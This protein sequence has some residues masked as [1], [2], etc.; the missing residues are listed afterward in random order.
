MESTIPN[1]LLKKGRTI[2]DEAAA[3]VQGGIRDAQHAA[4]EAGNTLSNKVDD[5]RSDAD[6]PIKRVVS[7]VKSVSR[8]GADAVGD[9]ASRVRDVALNTSDSIVSYTKKNPT[10]ALAIAAASGALLYAAIKASRRSR[11]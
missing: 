4:E 2:A 5:L 1:D 6:P 9:I 8:N 7:R 3:R 11:D 10:S